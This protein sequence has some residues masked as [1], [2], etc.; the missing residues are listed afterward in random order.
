MQNP[1]IY[2]LCLHEHHLENLKKLNYIPV[3]LG[4]NHFSNQ[5]IRDNKNIN[6]SQKNPFY[7]EYTF[8]YWFWKNVLE[9]IED[10]SWIGFTG[11][12]YH[13]SNSNKFSSDEINK[14]VNQEN[15]SDH[16]LRSIPN[17]WKDSNVIL[18]EEIFIDD[19]KLSKILK[20]GKKFFLKNPKFFIK[21][22]RNIKLHFDIFHG[23]NILDKAID[24]LNQE[25]RNDFKD[26]VNQER[27]FNRENLFFCRSKKIMNDYFSSVFNWLFECEKIFGF[28]LEGYG[29]K[30]LYAFLAERYISFWFKKYTR[31][32]TWPIFFY[33]T[34][35]NRIAI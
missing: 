28:D 15:F 21:K 17:E 13:W 12:R 18:G 4:E 10:N 27:S 1:K 26:F 20:H 30:R 14:Q 25:D 11:Y 32:K 2:C 31:I 34:N 35:K 6:I 23:Q 9:E 22:N 24:V 7:G 3:G 19:W 5:W 29:Q 33:D 8:Y 16:I